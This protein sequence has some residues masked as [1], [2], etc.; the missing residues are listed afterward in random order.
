MVSFII[1]FFMGVIIGMI[2]LS[3]LIA[4]KANTNDIIKE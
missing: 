4:G 2:I 1:G 3:L